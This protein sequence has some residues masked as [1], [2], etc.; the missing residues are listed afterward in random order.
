MASPDRVKMLILQ[1]AKKNLGLH[2]RPVRRSSC[3][4]PPSPIGE[5]RHEALLR[6][7]RL[8]TRASHS[9][10]SAGLTSSSGW[11]SRP[12]S[13]GQTPTSRSIPMAARRRFCSI[14]ARSSRRP[15]EVCVIRRGIFTPDRRANETPLTD[16]VDSVG[17]CSCVAQ[18]W[19]ASTRGS[20]FGADGYVRRWPVHSLSTSGQ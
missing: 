5:T 13:R 17:D 7:W 20:I 6:A 4:P 14:T 18:Q 2:R 1:G 3:R 19:R 15:P 9:R 11:V 10:R 12:V 16:G 8:I